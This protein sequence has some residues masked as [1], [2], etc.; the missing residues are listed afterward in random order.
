[1]SI[2]K[3]N[4]QKGKIFFALGA[5][6]IIFNDQQEIL[7]CHRTDKD[8]WNFPGGAVEPNETPLEAA[9]RET[10]EEIGVEAMATKFLGTYIKPHKNDVMFSF[11]GKITGGRLTVS[12]EADKIEYF[13]VQNLPT[14]FSPHQRE[15][16]QDALNNHPEAIFKKQMPY[17]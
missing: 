6:M 2:L 10:K 8:L 14:N 5:Q 11:L 1:M 12:D 7:L 16:I 3:A 4:T 13:S 15:R 9:F 17:E